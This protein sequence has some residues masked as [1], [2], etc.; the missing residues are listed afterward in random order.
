MAVVP[1]DR[2]P[3]EMLKAKRILSSAEYRSRA[4]TAAQIERMASAF[5]HGDLRAVIVEKKSPKSQ[6]KTAGTKKSKTKIA[7]TKAS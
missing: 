5:E 1:T 2:A 4:P 7:R 3:R 6:F